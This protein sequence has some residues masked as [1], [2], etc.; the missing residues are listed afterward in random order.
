MGVQPR[1]LSLE[2]K[3]RSIVLRR[4]PGLQ[5]AKASLIGGRSTANLGERLKW[6]RSGESKK[7]T[8]KGAIMAKRGNNDG[9]IIQLTDGRWCAFA[10]LGY[11]SGKRWRK[12]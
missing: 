2:G 12:K 11:R 7:T 6:P 10:H 1:T 8:G 5:L 3:V 9:T 4:V